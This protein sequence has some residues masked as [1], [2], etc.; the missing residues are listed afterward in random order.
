MGL[1]FPESLVL[2][3]KISTVLTN[4]DS[5][6]RDRRNNWGDVQKAV[7][8]MKLP[9]TLD[10][11][12]S[13]RDPNGTYP[14]FAFVFPGAGKGDLEKLRSSLIGNS[15]AYYKESAIKRNIYGYEVESVRMS[16]SNSFMAVYWRAGS[17]LFLTTGRSMDSLPNLGK[18]DLECNGQMAYD[19]MKAYPPDAESSGLGQAYADDPCS[20][21][22]DFN[23][24][25]ICYTQTGRSH[26]NLCST[27]TEAAFRDACYSDSAGVFGLND[28]EVCEKIANQTLKD[29]CFKDFNIWWSPAGW[30][31][32]VPVNPA[33]CARIQTDWIKD[34]CYEECAKGATEANVCNKIDN[35]GWKA[36]CLARFGIITPSAP[37]ND[38]NGS[39]T[40]GITAK[41][42]PLK[43]PGMDYC[44]NFNTIVKYDALGSR[45]Y[46]YTTN[47]EDGQY[48]EDNTCTSDQSSIC[49]DS[50]QGQDYGS[51]G[52]VTVN[53]SYWEGS[54]SDYC[55][56]TTRVV[57]YICWKKAPI[58]RVFDCPDGCVDGACV[59][60]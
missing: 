49:T 45:I 39:I 56:N 40:L 44:V 35:S 38:R 20:S 22:V 10:R 26:P 12:E 7:L 48:C 11:Y 13:T 8:M 27:L 33:L 24:K 53:N 21:V 23:G 25:R 52:I 54:L 29:Q 14:Y 41:V 19:L 36:K 32:T 30:H 46:N 60:K 17:N 6:E 37:H 31:P 15:Q 4:S 2:C 50:D 59:A 9:F 28:P 1:P 58:I 43:S 34:Q 55:L 57:E 16:D 18:E 51:K 3:K 5:V 47:C 42:T